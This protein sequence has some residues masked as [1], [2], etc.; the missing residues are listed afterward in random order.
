MGKRG[1][2]PKG[3]VNIKWSS[4]FAYALGLIAT[5]GCLGR[6]REHIDFT[7]KDL[8]QIENFKKC[9][10]ISAKIG[11]KVSGGGFVSRRIQFRNERFHAFL[12][13]IGLTPSKSKTVG[14]I[15]IP[16]K[17]FF[18]FLRGSFDGDGTFYSYWDKRWKSSFMFYTEFISASQDHIDWIR[19]EIYRRVGVKGHITTNLNNICKQLKYAKADSLKILRKMY[20]SRKVVSLSRKRLK[21]NKILAMIGEKTI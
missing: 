11:Y 9:L 7:S 14:K 20:H 2:K 6:D 21:I 4:N 10:G 1:P 12:V 3:N 17:Y 13:G 8:E 16:D 19:G 18:D 5:D 15:M